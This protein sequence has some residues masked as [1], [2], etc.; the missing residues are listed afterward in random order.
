ML[1][2]V[3]LVKQ[4]SVK[5][6]GANMDIEYI[7]LTG[8]P[9]EFYTHMIHRI[10]DGMT[11]PDGSRLEICGATLSEVKFTKGNKTIEVSYGEQA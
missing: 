1:V 4:V 11:G 5:I 6:Q 8:N 7:F 10:T 2:E 9:E 3:G